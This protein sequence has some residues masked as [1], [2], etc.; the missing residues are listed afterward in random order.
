MSTITR[1][2]LFEFLAGWDFQPSDERLQVIRDFYISEPDEEQAALCEADWK[3][4]PATIRE[5]LLD[6]CEAQ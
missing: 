2:D 3:D 4:V 1:D 5:A 6:A